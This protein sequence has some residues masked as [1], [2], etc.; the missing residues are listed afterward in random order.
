MCRTIIRSPLLTSVIYYLFILWLLITD[1]IFVVFKTNQMNE[2]Q[3]AIIYSFIIQSWKLWKISSISKPL[4]LYSNFPVKQNYTVRASSIMGYDSNKNRKMQVR[5]IKPCKFEC[6][7]VRM[8]NFNCLDLRVFKLFPLYFNFIN[9]VNESYQLMWS[10][11][12]WK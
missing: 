3:S 6:L 12:S 2:C 11:G 5:C 4:L 8:A 9:S 7:K 1:T 10:L